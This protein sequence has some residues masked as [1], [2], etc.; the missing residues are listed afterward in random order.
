MLRAAQRG[1]LAPDPRS[2]NEA[3]LPP[4][5]DDADEDEYDDD[6]FTEPGGAPSSR[7][8]FEA[9]LKTPQAPGIPRAPLVPRFTPPGSVAPSYAPPPDFD[10]TPPGFELDLLNTDSSLPLASRPISDTVSA[11]PLS[12]PPSTDR[13]RRLELELEPEPEVA[14]ELGPLDGRS[15]EAAA[16]RAAA[17]RTAKVTPEAS[18]LPS[19][20]LIATWLADHDYERALSAIEGMG[21]E[22]S[23][24]LSLLEVR[25]QLGL[26]RKGAAR[27]ALDR[28][29][30]AP[31]ID[32][33][34][35][36]AAAR[37][38]IEL[39][40]LDR[41]E[42]QARRAHSE[43]PDAELS[44]LTLSWA[45]ARTDSW[46]PSP[47]SAA[48]L[49]E[50]LSEFTPDA[51]PMPALGYALR[52]LVL[53][54][55]GSLEQ[56]RIAADSAVALDPSSIDGHAAAALIAQKQGRQ[57]D[58]IRAFNRLLELDHHAA[59]E[60]SQTLSGLGLS[61][62]RSNTR[63]APAAPPPTVLLWDVAEH[64]LHAGQHAAAREPF[65]LCLCERLAAISSSPGPSD[66]AL[67]ASVT[68]CF[69]TE[70]P[71]SRHFA[72][73]DRSLFSIARLDAVLGLL[74]GSG[75]S[76][77]HL[78]RRGRVLLGLG[79]YAGECLRQAYA[80]EWM[81]SEGDP[82]GRHVEGQGLYFTPFREVSGR[83]LSGKPLH[84]AQSPAPHHP[85]AEPLG[86]RVALDLTPP[87]PWDPAAWP[88]S[89]EIAELGA[90]LFESPVGLYCAATELPLDLSL[91]SLRGLDRYVTLLAPPLAPP[92]PEAAWVRR[93]AVMVGAYLGETLRE[94][95]GAR[96]DTARDVGARADA[97]KLILLNGDKASPIAAA[98]D[99]LSGR[100][101]EQPS[102]YVR[103]LMG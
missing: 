64:Q 23:P 79:A 30:R 15:A 20:F 85:G 40:D 10:L 45:I 12:G 90:R 65:E 1:T 95:A 83:L 60:L 5:A 51:C 56:G 17:S 24:E 52:A 72:P 71:I 61:V 41:A 57:A 73:F 35:R 25:A 9:Q 88:R 32:P 26:G 4:P 77:A 82:L 22:Q 7:P 75:E 97:F 76:S 67:A 34:L 42:A 31:L 28:L 91:A 48:E 86:H 78:E 94:R 43:D 47:R 2:F 69:L 70:S 16:G 38:L 96:W 3:T 29:C 81:G 19:V 49:S 74:Y 98:F 33:D 101:L 21:A 36:A 87:S 103:R 55:S 37:L 59:D 80:G 50:L 14:V 63:P 18:E 13:G 102:D 62:G 99:R 39:G 68:A 11:P 89:S 84:I 54:Q 100:R 66:L 92:D 27:R 58:A 46:L 6:R 44:R 8:M 93:A 53:T